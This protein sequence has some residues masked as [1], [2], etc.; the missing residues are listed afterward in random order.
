VALVRLVLGVIFV[1]A[2]LLRGLGGGPAVLATLAGAF[3]LAVIALGQRSRAGS[4]D[5]EEALAVPPDAGFD[6]GWVGVVL[7]CV[8]STIGVSVMAVLALVVS[9]ALAAVLGGVLIAL[10]ILA[11]SFWKQLTARER[12]EQATYWIERGPRPRL[13]VVRR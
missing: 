13:F 5:F 12:R 11:A 8:P 7:A 6:A 1:V 2:A 9:P 10:G 4:T 3:L